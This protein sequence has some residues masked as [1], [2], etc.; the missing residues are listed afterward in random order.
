MITA[1]TRTAMTATATAAAEHTSGKTTIETR[2]M[3]FYYGAFRAVKDINLAIEPQKITALIG[4]SGCGKT[5]V[6][7]TFNRM[8]DLVPGTR[9]DGEVLFHGKNLYAPDVDAVEV[10]R[11]IGMVFQKPNPFPKS[12]YENIAFG[13]RINGWRG[14]KRDMDA[15]VERSLRSAALWDD[16]KDK[17]QQPGTALS[18][19]QQ[20]RLCIARALAVEPEIILMDEPCSALD[21]ISTIKIEELMFQLRREYTIV[22]V[23]HNMQQAARA[24]DCTAFFLMDPADRAGQLIEY[25]PTEKLFTNPHDKRTEEYITGRFG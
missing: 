13:P 23:T 8:N 21:P 3:H 17:L 10:R 5:T 16:V 11:R 9:L 24:S 12:I 2:N 19:G 7:R 20:Q 15:L 4:P 22:I 14:S 18:G 6:L 25:G 1:T